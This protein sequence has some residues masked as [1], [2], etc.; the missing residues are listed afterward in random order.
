[1]KKEKKKE[2]KKRP[3]I[4][5]L[6]IFLCVIAVLAAL[7]AAGEL[8]DRY[9]NPVITL[10]SESLTVELGGEGIDSE[11]NIESVEFGDIE[12]VLVEDDVDLGNPGTYTVAY[13]LRESTC[14]A[15]VT[16]EDTTPPELEL[17]DSVTDYIWDEISLE[18]F[19]VQTSDLQ[20]VSVYFKEEYDLTEPGEYTVAVIAEDASGN[21]TEEY[22]QLI[23]LT[24]T[25]PPVISGIE[26][27]TTE[28]GTKVDFS[29]G[30]TVSDDID[31]SPVL[32]VDSSSVSFYIAGT[33]TITYTATD[34]CGNTTTATQKL[35]VKS[36][37]VLASSDSE[38]ETEDKI[39]YLTFDDGPSANMGEILDI[40]AAYEI[41]A[42]FFVTGNNASYRS[43]ITRAYNEGHSI[44]LHSYTHNYKTIYS[45]EEAFF[46]DLEKIAD[47]VEELTGEATNLLR[48]P[49]GSSNTVSRKYS[50]GIMTRL[51]QA[52]EDAG[53]IYFDWDVDSTD[54][55]ANNV[56]VSTLVSKSTASSASRIN[57][58]MHCTDAKDTTVEALPQ[59]IEYYL[60][61]GYTFRAL[62]DKS[63]VSHQKI[64]N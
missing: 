58:L 64:N 26:D 42:T 62:T 28:Y 29:G 38:E 63:A 5:A 19:V 59:I 50:S 9:N 61:Q 34:F 55:S 4:S 51:T 23:R 41:K 17:V 31:E 3:F 20:E 2:R 24:D 18:D 7:A 36:K 16:V 1:M 47:L 44:G 46:E 53:Y 56:P 60:E 15:Y 22:A 48:F 37:P 39:V 11:A 43:M 27:I 6:I 30:V 40:L 49:G 32:T 21:K 35:T 10:K 33:Y 13:S 12:D 14:Y 54:A 52:V 45:S 25:T 8:K 57:I